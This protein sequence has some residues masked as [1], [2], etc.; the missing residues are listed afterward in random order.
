MFNDQLRGLVEQLND[1]F[2]DA[3]FVYI[4][5]YNMFQDLIDN[6]GAY[7]TILSIL[8]SK[9]FRFCLNWYNTS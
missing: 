1:E 5:V 8:I 7:G 3:R 2:S 6:P 9:M 4:N